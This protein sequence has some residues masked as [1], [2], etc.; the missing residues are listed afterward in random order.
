MGRRSARPRARDAGR[1]AVEL[2]PFLSPE[3]VFSD[4]LAVVGDPALSMGEKRAILA[5]WLARICANEAAFRL[6]WV[7]APRAEA[8][9]FDDVMDALSALE[10]DDPRRRAGIG[11]AAAIVPAR[12]KQQKFAGTVH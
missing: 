2:E 8:V 5:R 3:A 9:Q 12:R 4:P 10:R 6:K 11:S 1:R 7:P